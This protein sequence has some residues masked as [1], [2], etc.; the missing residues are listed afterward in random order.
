MHERLKRLIAITQEI[1]SSE[2]INKLSRST[3]FI[4]RRSK[5][6][7]EAF[8][9]FNTFSSEDMCA[10]SLNRLSSRLSSQYNMQV[11]PQALNERYNSYS[12]EF[13]KEIFNSIMIKQNKIL[14]DKKKDLELNFNRIVLN[15]STNF[16]L[17]DDFEG[18]FKG[19]GGVASK[20]AIKIQFQ[21]EL[22]SGTFTCCDIFESTKNDADYLN[23]MADCIVPKDLRM[24]DLGY[25]KVEYLKEVQDK[26]AFF[27]SKVKSNTAIY[28]KNPNP[29]KS[30]S[31]EII[32]S[33]EYIKIDIKELAKPL[34]EGQTI[35]L[36]DIYIGAKKNLLMRLIVTKLTEENK[37]KR[38][39][40]YTKGLR[41][42]RRK[43]TQSNI[44]WSGLNA[45]I[46]N[47]SP[48]ILSTLQIHEVYSLRW[49]I[50]L[51][52]KIWK[53]IFNIHIVKKVKIE[54]FKCFLYGRLIALLLTSMIVSASG[55]NITEEKALEISS[56][57]A[58]GKIVE[59]FPLLRD[60]LFKGEL[61]II[62]I[63][64]KIN[65]DIGKSGKKSRRKHSKTSM[66]I[67]RSIVS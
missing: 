36:R 65:I 53:S 34:S 46:T 60:K 58:Y 49:Q 23:T 52:F 4:Q 47:V 37:K 63:F 2:Y 14:H 3:K 42:H 67:I 57:K 59:Y 6:N 33:Q 18:E 28:M 64:E 35:E 9:A 51:M 29:R 15:D 44:D 17:P 7:A 5:I 10:A 61:A 32:K 22:L 50:E 31:G 26:G 39:E 21:Y 8:F 30:K 1:F 24:S 40:K 41:K 55:K 66:D 62:R 56:I 16:K 20:S 43:V 19:T 11:S 45:Y 48:E 25:F 38:E 54:R 13:M 12:V 27:I